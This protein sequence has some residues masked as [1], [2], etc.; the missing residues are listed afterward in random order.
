MITREELT[1]QATKAEKRRQLEEA[2]PD[3]LAALKVALAAE[4]WG[5]QGDPPWAAQARAAIAKAEGKN[6]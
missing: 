4:P 3:L 6:Q 2:A 1:A 5:D